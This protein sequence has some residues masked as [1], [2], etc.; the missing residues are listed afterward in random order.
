[1]VWWRTQSSQAIAA[2]ID[3][4]RLSGRTPRSFAIARSILST[5]SGGSSGGGGSFHLRDLH[6]GH[7]SGTRSGFVHFHEWPHC[8]HE[9]IFSLSILR[10]L[11]KLINFRNL[12]ILNILVLAVARCF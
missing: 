8:V 6:C 9:R 3:F 7:R 10:C 11:G 1:M 2:Q 5:T 4:F 12:L